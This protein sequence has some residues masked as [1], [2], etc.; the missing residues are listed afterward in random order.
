MSTSI[1]ENRQFLNAMI[2]EDS[3]FS[4]EVMVFCPSCKAFETVWFNRGAL[5]Q[6][7]KFTQYGHHIYHDCGSKEPCR[8]YITT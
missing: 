8:L 7:R 5:N 4:K 2:A 1:V 3:R 6:T